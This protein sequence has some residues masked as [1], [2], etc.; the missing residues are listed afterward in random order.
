MHGRQSLHFFLFAAGGVLLAAAL[1]LLAC[2]RAV[3]GFAQAYALRIYPVF[4]STMGGLCSLL[5]VSVSEFGL[6]LLLLFCLYY[7]ASHIRQPLFLAS[8]GFF[9]GS[10]LFFVYMINCGVNYYRTPF[11]YEAGLTTAPASTEELYSLCKLLVEKINEEAAAVPERPSLSPYPGQTEDTPSPSWAYLRE[12]GQLG[13]EAMKNLGEVYPQLAG[14]YPYPKPLAISR[15]LSVQQLC[16][17]YSPFTVEANYNREMPLYNIPHTI[18]HE[19]SHLKGYMREDEANFIGYLACIGSEDTAFRYSGYLTGW[20]Y[21]GNALAQADFDGYRRLYGQL[22]PQAVQDLGENN[23]F[24]DRFKGKVAEAS[25]KMNDTYLK[26]HS[27]TDGIK[28]YGRMVDL[29]LTY[30][31]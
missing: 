18:C 31:R 22:D 23:A 7:I 28:S 16:G 6:Y 26:A 1:I 5:P 9:L 8:R 29:M 2:A 10:L 24:W 3:P 27:Q 19:L 20:V 30:Y 17:I 4:K 13:R 25:A 14:W 21:A 11:S 15:I 12:M